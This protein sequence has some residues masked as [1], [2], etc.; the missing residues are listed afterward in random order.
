MS[1]KQ[2]NRAEDP[3]DT[4][5]A[6]EWQELAR[7]A[8]KKKKDEALQRHRDRRIHSQSKCEEGEVTNVNENV[9]VGTV[10]RSQSL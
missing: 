3:F 5:S 9:S 7:L 10:I 2:L 1:Y 6:E 8:K 4:I